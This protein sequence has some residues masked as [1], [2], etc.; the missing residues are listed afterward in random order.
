MVSA[1]LYAGLIAATAAERLCELALSRRNAALCR[2]RGG[3]ERG[4]GHFPFMVALHTGL[5]AGALA[6]VWFLGRPFVPG[7]GWPM[8][9]LAVACQGLRWWAIRTLGQR[10]NTRV[11]VVPGLA[12][13]RG[14][15][16]YR[17]LDHP[18]Y[19]AVVLEGIA[20]PLVHSA[21]VTAVVFTVL[22]I[23]LLA[24][25]VRCEEAALAEA[26]AAGATRG[27]SMPTPARDASGSLACGGE[28]A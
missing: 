26:A 8:L 14:A 19:L 3:V 22:N 15:G 7:L 12:P 18:N 27:T 21:W 4:A 9:A 23:P 17:F 6:E 24:V 5:L 1:A 13:V 2:A 11:I 10:W 20:L 28:P 25:R 16:P